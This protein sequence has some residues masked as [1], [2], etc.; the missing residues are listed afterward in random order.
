MW[1]STHQRVCLEQSQMWKSKVLTK[2][3]KPGFRQSIFVQDNQENTE[4]PKAHLLMASATQG[5]K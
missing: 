5:Y 4:L 1:R 3:N 2:E